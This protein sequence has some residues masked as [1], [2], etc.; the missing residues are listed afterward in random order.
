MGFLVFVFGV[1]V[2]YFWSSDIYLWGRLSAYG[3]GAR[4]LLICIA[5]IF[6]IFLPDSRTPQ[7]SAPVFTLADAPDDPF[8]RPIYLWG[9]F[10]KSPISL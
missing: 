9:R 4:K 8:K 5:L 6:V 7:T 3:V 2:I 10:F 1:V